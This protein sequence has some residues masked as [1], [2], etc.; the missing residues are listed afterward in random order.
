MVKPGG[1]VLAL[2]LSDVDW[3]AWQYLLDE[4]TSYCHRQFDD[5]G[6][7]KFIEVILFYYSDMEYS[8]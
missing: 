7:V 8:Q 6:R 5:V 2:P 3:N 4:L 1:V